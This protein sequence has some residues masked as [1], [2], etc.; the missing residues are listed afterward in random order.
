MI[1]PHTPYR[2]VVYFPKIYTPYYTLARLCREAPVIV[3]LVSFTIV[4]AI[5]LSV[6]FIVTREPRIKLS[7]TELNSVRSGIRPQS[8]LSLLEIGTLLSKSF[9]P[10]YVLATIFD[11]ANKG[12][13][14]I[15][16]YGES[17]IMEPKR[18]DIRK[19]NEIERMI[20]E[21]VKYVRDIKTFLESN[22]I[23][24]LSE[25]SFERLTKLG[26]LKVL[27]RL[28][29][30]S[31][32]FFI[33]SFILLMILIMLSAL[34]ANIYIPSSL[35]NLLDYLPIFISVAIGGIA[36]SVILMVT[37]TQKLTEKGV[38]EKILWKEYLNCISRK[39]KELK[40]PI[41]AIL[42]PLLLVYTPAKLKK[43]LPERIP[44]YYIPWYYP[45]Y[46][47]TTPGSLETP[48]KPI[49][50]QLSRFIEALS[51]TLKVSAPSTG[52]STTPTGVGAT[53]GGG[54]GG[55]GIA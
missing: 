41:G 27:N 23:N 22:F 10:R 38:R 35:S 16:D 28:S 55:G 12:Y 3:G 14:R 18:R 25:K 48:M 44:I 1:P 29:S 17:L 40:L 32:L 26:Y 4:L 36:S 33:G 54:G 53:G 31:I 9:K 50:V 6:R 30:F 39:Y 5:T 46:Y 15:I 7:I 8:E 24:N 47:Y 19:L 42:A 43:I 45:Y 11:L 13:F 51:N 52:P 2:I 37:A 20:Y 49:D 21:R 34:S